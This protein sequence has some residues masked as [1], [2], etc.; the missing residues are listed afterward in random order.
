MAI[1]DLGEYNVKHLN[2]TAH[3][4]K[5]FGN[6]AVCLYNYKSANTSYVTAKD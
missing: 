5:N 3:R 2:D 4:V 1:R 6:L